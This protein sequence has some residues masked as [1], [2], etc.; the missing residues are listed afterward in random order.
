VLDLAGT[1]DDEA[2]ELLAALGSSLGA[3]L[4]SLAN[5]FE[6]EMFVIGGG[7]GEAAGDH[8]L[9]PARRV[10]RAGAL[11]PMCETPVAAAVLGP[12]AGMIGAAQLVLDAERAARSRGPLP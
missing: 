11:H 10:L 3:G 8:L 1:F 7:F 9:E 12:D 4:V 6:T 2:L 5:A